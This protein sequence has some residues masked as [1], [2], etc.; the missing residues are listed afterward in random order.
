[1]Q[2]QAEA[3][4]EAQAPVACEVGAV[5]A[6]RDVVECRY[7]VRLKI[8]CRERG[9][10]PALHALGIADVDV[11]Q[12]PYGDVWV[13]LQSPRRGAEDPAPQSVWV[14]ER[15]TLADLASSIKDGRYK[16]QKLRL[17]A[18]V[19]ASRL[20]YVIESKKQW[21]YTRPPCCDGLNG[22]VMLGAVLN[23]MV[24]DGISVVHTSGMEE[25]ASLIKEVYTRVRK[26]PAKYS[27]AASGHAVSTDLQDQAY[28]NANIS[29]RKR[30]LSGERD[31]FLA[32]LSMIPGVSVTIAAQVVERFGTMANMVRQ[33]DQK[34]LRK[35]R[36]A[37]LM[38]FDHVGKKTGSAILD[39]VF[40]EGSA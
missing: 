20:A 33:L 37:C 31:C 9:L 23:T 18:H 5:D 11:E 26:E 4:A 30:K 35:E 24:R 16:E 6:A 14:L 2:A 13:C 34:P 10:A 25:T 39:A 32:Q 28:V 12:L 21:S 15:K 36:L 40:G 22:N 19:P 29:A 27:S 7:D 3:E 1:M 17:I 38:A 8:D